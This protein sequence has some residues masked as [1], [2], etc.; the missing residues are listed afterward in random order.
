MVP[1]HRMPTERRKNYSL[2]L[3]TLYICNT[4]KRQNRFH[5]SF[6]HARI[7]WRNIDSKKKRIFDEINTLEHMEAIEAL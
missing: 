2:E 7:K 4:L 6:T 5:H 1:C 3:F